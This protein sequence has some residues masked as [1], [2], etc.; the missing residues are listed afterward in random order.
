MSYKSSHHEASRNQDSGDLLQVL[1]V[2]RSQKRGATVRKTLISVL[3]VG[4]L[5][6]T[7]HAAD[8]G[9]DSLPKVPDSLSWAGVTIYGTIDV[10]GVTQDHGAQ[11]SDFLPT[12]VNYQMYGGFANNHSIST[13]AANGL[14]QSKVG[15]K[16]EES[17]G[18]L[19]FTA[20][21]KIE[22]GFD[23]MSGELA[24]GCKS[25]LLNNGRPQFAQN[26][27]GDSSRCGQAF[28]GPVY[29]GLSSATWGTLTYGRQQS[30]GLDTVAVYDP[31]ALSYAFS[32]LGYTGNAYG[33]GATETSR[34]D[35]SVK[36]VYQYGPA[37][38]AGMYSSGGPETGMF[39]GG[40][41]ANVGVTY[42]GF[43]ID[44]FYEHENGAVNIPSP[45]GVPT[46]GSTTT[47]PS[48]TACV[49]LNGVLDCPNAVPAFISDNTAWSVE[50]K[51][52]FDIDGGGYKD[53]GGG[54]KDQTPIPA[55]KVTIYAGY[56][57]V[58]FANPH[59][60]AQNY[61][62]TIGGYNIIPTNTRF[63]TDLT[64]E[65][66]WTG[67][68]Y[69]I[70][71]WSFT[72]AYY[73]YGTSDYLITADALNCRQETALNA[74][75]KTQGTFFGDPVGANCHGDFNEVSFVVDYTFNKHFDTYVGVNWS[76]TNG[77]LNSSALQTEQWSVVSGLRLKW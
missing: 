25:V 69:E 65:L 7:A 16:I 28:S 41:G 36:Y 50:A 18:W 68:R 14:E 46:P 32:I 30:L 63:H 2:N 19:D 15:L 47:V 71:K 64:R 48:A 44:G 33:D 53:G 55:A 24:D 60:F 9:L 10:N 57:N 56:I 58:D 17:L 4:G 45:L 62:Q 1:H 66:A 77:G 20:I 72:A 54:Y 12:T 13:L 22:A 75:H 37:H 21:G 31:Q 23:P 51:Y 49:N 40:Y 29:A 38:V 74:L 26:S 8:L 42:A 27:N 61:S 6:A 43:S 76:E 35:N 67:V 59:N 34:W 39:G 52:T 70:D 3:A 73:W 5:S 11:K